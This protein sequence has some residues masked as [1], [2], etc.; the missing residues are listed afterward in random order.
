MVVRWHQVILEVFYCIC[1][2]FLHLF[3]ARLISKQLWA[4]FYKCHFKAL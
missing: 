4:A 1:F 3:A 2:Y